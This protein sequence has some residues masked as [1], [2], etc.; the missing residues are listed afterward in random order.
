MS[1]GRPRTQDYDLREDDEYLIYHSEDITALAQMSK[2]ASQTKYMAP[3]RAH[4]FTS[5]RK[6]VCYRQRDVPEECKV[7]IDKEPYGACGFGTTPYVFDFVR[8]CE[9]VIEV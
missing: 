3:F 4:R 8:K 5:C 7:A 9:K 2:S 6:E 1:G